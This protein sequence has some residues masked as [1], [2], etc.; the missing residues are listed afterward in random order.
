M[1]LFLDTANL[2]DIGKAN[3]LGIIDGVTTNPV[4]LSRESLGYRDGIGSIISLMGERKV[5]A[6]VL[7]SDVETICREARELASWGPNM[8]IKLP[9]SLEGIKA[10]SRLK[11]DGIPTCV[12]LIYTAPQA[13]LAAQAG[14]QYVAPFIHRGYEA[15]LDGMALTET[16]C[17]TF[18][19]GGL[20]CKVLAASL[21]T[22]VDVVRAVQAGSQAITLPYAVLCSMVDN[23]CST[24][25]LNAFMDMWESKNAGDIF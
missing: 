15:G 10:V 2:E 22:S 20:G 3:D 8:V 4:L 24:A 12:T 11:K 6:Q 5:F 21:R 13:V 25:T 16:I 18:A 14:A 17:K 9:I 23:S 19:A 7:A 1:E